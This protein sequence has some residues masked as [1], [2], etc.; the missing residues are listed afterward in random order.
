MPAQHSQP[1][2][3]HPP[4]LSADPA[5]STLTGTEPACIAVFALTDTGRVREHNEDVYLVQ[6]TGSWEETA[7]G[8]VQYAHA[9]REPLLLM[10]SDGM[11][12]AAAGEVASRL[13]VETVRDHFA[14]GDR[15]D[16][17]RATAE[18]ERALLGANRAVYQESCAGDGREGMGATATAALV[19]DGVLYLGQVGD[20]RAYLLR[21]GTLHP[22]SQDQSLVGMLVEA[23]QVT[24]EVARTHPQRHVLLQALGTREAVTP[25]IATLQLC[26]GDRLLLCSDGLSGFLQ[27][28]EIAAVLTGWPDPRPAAEELV[29]LA[30]ER[31]GED[32]ITVVL[33]DL[34]SDH[35]P[36]PHGCA[37]ISER[38][39]SYHFG[40]GERREEASSWKRPLRGLSRLFGR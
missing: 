6:H 35:L 31:G 2:P 20:S 12:G 23:G 30:N 21:S 37:V 1:Q 22:V 5:L 17:K 24:P 40:E 33:T 13:A 3:D 11:G 15:F 16:P 25:A 10:V 36:A 19:L 7:E 29:R 32:N 38:I 27:D 18:M 39:R 8:A 4:A 28:E 14:R 9:A 26:R 34:G